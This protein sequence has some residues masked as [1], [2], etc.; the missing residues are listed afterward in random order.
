[1]EK[2]L[3]L[4]PPDYSAPAVYLRVLRCW[5]VHV[6]LES[7]TSPSDAAEVHEQSGSVIRWA[8]RLECLASKGSPWSELPPRADLHKQRHMLVPTA[9]SWL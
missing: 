2:Q 3:F 5:G 4:I 8:Q 6:I 9:N 7:T 1:M